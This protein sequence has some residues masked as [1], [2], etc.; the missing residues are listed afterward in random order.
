VLQ[1]VVATNNY[2]QQRCDATGKLGLSSIQK[3]TAALRILCY[4]VSSDATDEYVR[5]GDSTALQSFKAFVE[6]VCECFGQEY[7]RQPT[8]E[9]IEKQT[10]INTR[11]G[12]PGMFGSLNCTHWNWRN[13]AVGL[14]GQYRDKDGNCS[15]ILEAV[16]SYHLWI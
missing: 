12:F 4:G 6:A 5:I 3:V 2:F 9:D 8:Q 10:A 11:R 15:I 1:G 7:L 13:C 16:A 14:H